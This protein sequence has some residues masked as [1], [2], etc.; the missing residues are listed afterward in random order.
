MGNYHHHR[1]TRAPKEKKKKEEREKKKR[2]RWHRRQNW[3]GVISTLG[4][5]FTASRWWRRNGRAAVGNSSAQRK[6]ADEITTRVS[7][8]QVHSHPGL[9]D[10]GP[11]KG[12]SHKDTPGLTVGRE[13]TPPTSAASRRLDRQTHTHKEHIRV[14]KTRVE[15]IN[16]ST[17]L[18]SASTCENTAT[19]GAEFGG[20]CPPLQSYEQG[21][22]AKMVRNYPAS[23]CEPACEILRIRLGAPTPCPRRLHSAELERFSAPVTSRSHRDKCMRSATSQAKESLDCSTHAFSKLE[24]R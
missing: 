14:K 17:L 15:V 7:R 22:R 10:D 3:N 6:A 9:R 5:V 21:E 23:S 4:V 12:A 16:A 11:T 24:I 19:S 8:R 2:K 20:E 13:D 1:T 18:C